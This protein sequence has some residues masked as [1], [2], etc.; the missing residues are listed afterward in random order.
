M[1]REPWLDYCRRWPGRLGDLLLTGSVAHIRI[2]FSPGAA[3]AEENVR[4]CA[5]DPV[6]AAEG[7]E[8]RFTNEAKTGRSPAGGRRK[9]SNHCKLRA[10][11]EQGV[12]PR[13]KE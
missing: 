6:T 2:I 7:C 4:M 10:G 5:T 12:I 3:K 8:F 13:G 1:L 11:Q 9:A